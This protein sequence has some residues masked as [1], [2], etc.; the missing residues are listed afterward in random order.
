VSDGIDLSNNNQDP[1][2]VDWTGQSFAICKTSEG[3]GFVDTTFG[4]W[5]SRAARHGAMLGAYHFAHPDVNTAAAE[6]EFFLPLRGAAVLLALDVESRTVV[7]NHQTHETRTFDPLSILGSA[8]LASWVDAWCSSVQAATGLKPFVYC[9]RSYLTALSP[10]MGDWP[11]WLATAT[12]AP[13]ITRFAGRAIAIEQWGSPGGVDHN[14]AFIDLEEYPMVFQDD[15]FANFTALSDHLD[16]LKADLDAFKSDVYTNF[17]YL[18]D[19]KPDPR[20]PTQPP[21]INVAALAQAIVDAGAG[22]AVV[23]ELHS[24]LS[25]G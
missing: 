11:I 24:R 20:A 22:Q 23:D 13:G 17:L 16:A 2:A 3:T 21:P 7:I 1:A 9:N 14:T 4:A 5:A 15:V 10:H 12:G 8:A 25:H 6:V 18:R 19:I